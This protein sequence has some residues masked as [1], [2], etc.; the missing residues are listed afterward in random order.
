MSEK[1]PNVIYLLD[2][3]DWGAVWCDDP[4][5]AGLGEDAPGS[6]EY[7][8]HDKAGER[9]GGWMHTREVARR[10][11]V[12]EHQRDSLKAA[13]RECADALRDEV[14]GRRGSELDRRIERDLAP[15][16][17]AENVLANLHE[18]FQQRPLP[19]KQPAVPI[20]WLRY[21]NVLV[22]VDDAVEGFEVCDPGDRGDD[23][24]A[25]FPVYDAPQPPAEQPA[26]SVGWREAIQRVRD[27]RAP[28]GEG[29]GAEQE[30]IIAGVYLDE[31]EKEIEA[32]EQGGGVSDAI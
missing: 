2:D 19:A 13:L 3:P 32:L 15:A 8:R 23:G 31:V 5:P 29:V 9:L 28:G 11:R 12:L 27:N 22:A 26:V 30:R 1:Y 7:V 24:S 17:D 20:A 16:Y 14:E 25:A 18:S 10:E 4:D 21:R 6:V